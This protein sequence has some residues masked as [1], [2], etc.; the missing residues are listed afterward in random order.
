M[1][2]SIGQGEAQEA[3]MTRQ[4]S[5]NTKYWPYTEINPFDSYF[6]KWRIYLFGETNKN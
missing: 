1:M 6:K 2:E 5:A 3:F 4:Q